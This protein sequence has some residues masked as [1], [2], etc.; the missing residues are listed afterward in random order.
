MHIERIHNIDNNP[1]NNL[2]ENL[3]LFANTGKHRQYH[4]KNYPLKSNIVKN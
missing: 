2:P 3:Y 1:E 4:G